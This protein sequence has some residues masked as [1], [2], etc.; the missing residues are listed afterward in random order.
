METGNCSPTP[1]KVTTKD[2]KNIYTNY[3]VNL[4]CLL[5][6]THKKQAYGSLLKEHRRPES[7]SVPQCSIAVSTKGRFVQDLHKIMSPSFT[8]QRKAT[9][10]PNSLVCLTSG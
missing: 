3:F 6:K 10:E 5:A 4:N 7:V 9:L 2:L 8:H 1:A